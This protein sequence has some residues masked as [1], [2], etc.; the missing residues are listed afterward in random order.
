MLLRTLLLITTCV[1]FERVVQGSEPIDAFLEKHCLRCHG[2]QRE[3]GDIR[4]DR[5]SR[6]FRAGLDTHHW[7]EVLDKVNSG[8]MPPK[9]EPQPTQ[10]EISLFVASLDSRLQEGRAVR[11]AS[12][13]A[14]A[15]YRLSRREYQ[16]TVYDLLGVRYDPTKPGELNE[17]TL[18]HGFERLGSQLS[19]SASHIDRYYRA[20]G[21][22]LERAYPE[23]SAE[24]RTVRKT[25]AELRYSGGKNQQE[26][27]ERFGIRRPLR[28]LLY[29]GSTHNAL[30]PHWFGKVGPEHS[31]LYKVRIQASGVRP[32]NGQTGA[33]EYWQ[34]NERRDGGWP[35]R[36]RHYG[37]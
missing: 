26:A 31:G 36:V 21:L 27:L 28:F 24:A 22:V 6:D 14:V 20:A 3:E 15:H 7:A 35:D 32:L 23:L 30:S 13:P 29:P 1:G 2:P 12:R 16:N 11:M 8:S 34:A 4:I 5:L 9:D 10:S 17:D 18:W 25:A 37:T 33:S 19:L